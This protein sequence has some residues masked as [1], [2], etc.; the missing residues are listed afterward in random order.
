MVFLFLACEPRLERLLPRDQET[1]QLDRSIYELTWDFTLI[2]SVQEA[3]RGSVLF[4]ENGRGYWDNGVLRVKNDSSRGD[5]FSWSLNE[6]RLD[7]RFDFPQDDID[8]P[9]QQNFSFNI[10]ENSHEEQIWRHEA[11]F[12]V[13]NPQTRDSADGRLLWQWQLSR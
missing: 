2:E 4:L 11:N 6:E 3:D 1:W 13:Y 8:A 5:S 9:D 10:L 12:E 7:L